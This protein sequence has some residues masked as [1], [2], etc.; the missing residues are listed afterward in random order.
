VLFHYLMES[1]IPG[2]PAHRLS[3]GVEHPG[4]ELDA[5][6]AARWADDTRF[7]DANRRFLGGTIEF[8]MADGSTRPVRCTPFASGTGFHLGTGL[9]FGFDG[10]RHGQW[11]GELHVAGA[12]VG[13]CDAHAVA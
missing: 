11:R 3:G 4:G 6:V 7:D 10:A 2:Q 1:N 9:Y 5:F 13:C 12:D 8:T